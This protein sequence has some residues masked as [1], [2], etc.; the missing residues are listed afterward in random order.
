MFAHHL[1]RQGLNPAAFGA[2]SYPELEARGEA[3]AAVGQQRGATLSRWAPLPFVVASSKEDE[4]AQALRLPHPFQR[5]PLLEADLAFAVDLSAGPEAST[6]RQNLENLIPNL[7]RSLV[8][9]DE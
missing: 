4:V 7:Q 6:G 1:A 8:S 3:Q 5:S 2:P 9:F